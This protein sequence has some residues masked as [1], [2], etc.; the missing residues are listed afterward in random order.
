MSEQ[1]LKGRWR[2]K[3]MDHWDQALMD[4]L[5]PAFIEFL[6]NGFGS[7][8]FGATYVNLD[9]QLDERGKAEFSFY[10]DDEGQEVFGRGW[11]QKDNQGLYGMVFF[12]E[13]EQSSFEAI[14]D[15]P[16]QN[17][18]MPFKGKNKRILRRERLELF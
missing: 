10:G 9:Y 18:S 14:K 3:S 6:D 1:G 4:V 8:H 13:G 17:P 15:H 16:D 2:I 7:L 5:E 12:H 11:A